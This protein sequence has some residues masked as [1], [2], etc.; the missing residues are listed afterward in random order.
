MKY[1][2]KYDIG[3]RV[4]C[5]F[6]NDIV[7]M[8]ET[9]STDT[10]INKVPKLFIEFLNDNYDASLLSVRYVPN[11]YFELNDR[12]RKDRTLICE[13]IKGFKKHNR[14]DEINIRYKPLVKRKL[15]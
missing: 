11:I 1:K 13:T 4:E 7:E 15:K 14:L 6:T 10:W 9:I 8:I 12:F 5:V 3:E 2:S